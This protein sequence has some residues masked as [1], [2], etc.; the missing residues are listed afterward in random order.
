MI[1][2]GQV[3]A[4]GLYRLCVFFHCAMCHSFFSLLVFWSLQQFAAVATADYLNNPIF[5]HS[6][7]LP[8]YPSTAISIKRP[9]LSTSQFT[10]TLS[11]FSVGAL[12]FQWRFAFTFLLFP[13]AIVNLLFPWLLYL[14]WIA[15]HYIAWSEAFY[16]SAYSNKSAEKH[17]SRELSF[18]RE[19]WEKT[20]NEAISDCKLLIIIIKEKKRAV[21]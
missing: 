9:L 18:E 17:K 1:D 13:S 6:F 19:H 21:N 10:I 14:I 4:S 11:A 20:R 8:F 2:N 16:F 5:Y 15:A 3:S 7:L 12:N